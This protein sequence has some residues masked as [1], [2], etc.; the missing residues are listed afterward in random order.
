MFV[1]TKL[2]EWPYIQ[3]LILTFIMKRVLLLI[4]L[5]SALLSCGCRNNS[6]HSRPFD[7]RDSL[8]VEYMA[9]AGLFY[10]STFLDWDMLVGL[11]LNQNKAD[12][13]A[14]IERAI[15]PTWRGNEAAALYWDRLQSAKM[16]LHCQSLPLRA[17]ASRRM[18]KELDAI[19]HALDEA[20]IEMVTQKYYLRVFQDV[21]DELM[22]SKVDDLA[23]ALAREG[24]W[25]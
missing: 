3:V 4:L 20:F 14:E 8:V 19:E 18:L 16:C 11:N 2:C 25:I 15:H 7:L 9:Y 12:W 1:V 21:F 24:R 5:G 6:S 23:M 13:G 10:D 17:I 22:S